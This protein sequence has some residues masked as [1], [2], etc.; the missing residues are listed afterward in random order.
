MKLMNTI[1][2]GN[3]IL[4]S[5]LFN[6]R[7]PVSVIFSVTNKCNFD[8]GFC[9]IWKDVKKE[10]ATKEI[11]LLFDELAELGTQNITLFGG[12]PLLRKDMG[13]IIDYGKKKGFFMALNTNAYLLPKRFSEI[14]N[15]DSLL[16]SLEGP[17]QIND[18]LRRK[19]SY[20]SVIKG[21][22]LANRNKIPV[23]TYTVL[24][25]YNIDQIDFILNKA[26]E[27]NF[28]ASFLYLLD[29]P[30]TKKN[31]YG[32]FPDKSEYK[33][34]IKKLIGYKKSG[35]PVL[36]SLGCLKYMYGLPYPMKKI[37]C[38][39][40]K[41]HIY[42]ASDGSIYSCCSK[43]QHKKNRKTFPDIS[44]KES[45]RDLY[46]DGGEC[47]YCLFPGLFER[48]K[49]FSLNPEAILGVLKK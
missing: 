8:C 6:K 7:T 5:R 41:L 46:I 10:L 32:F 2:T 18:K 11:F 14:K 19:G 48:N 47:K 44:L 9:N 16:I 27:L 40:G 37:E 49:I 43:R 23:V 38:W 28:K 13:K 34:T 20:D 35:K 31:I 1:K 4:M 24:T 17:R 3:C 25:K 12:E 22:R 45:F 33:E 26:E 39:A 15:V 21:I 29:E 36:N 42:I 30:A